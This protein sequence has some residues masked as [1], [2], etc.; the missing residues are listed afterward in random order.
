MLLLSNSM[1]ALLCGIRVINV[2]SAALVHD[3]SK[4]YSTYILHRRYLLM[5]KSV[6]I[7]DPGYFLNKESVDILAVLY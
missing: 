3:K 1:K 4:Q 6:D 7:L 2:D 5:K